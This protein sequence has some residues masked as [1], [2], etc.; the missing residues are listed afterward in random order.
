MRPASRAPAPILVAVVAVV[1]AGALV[2][3]PWAGHQL[4]RRQ[5]PAARH[6]AGASVT[7]ATTPP[8]NSAAAPALKKLPMDPH[9]ASGPGGQALARPTPGRPAVGSPA[10]ARRAPDRPAAGG[11]VAATGQPP[12]AGGMVAAI[13]PETGK[14]GLPNQEQMRRL[15][16]SEQARLSHSSIGLVEVHHPDGSVSVDVGDRFQEFETVR[17]GPDGKKTFR[18]VSDTTVISKPDKKAAPA[19]DPAR[20][21]AEGR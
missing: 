16:E 6:A 2:A 11:M 13:D 7:R 18:C 5:A 8:P 12:A 19:A 4:A 14:L 10:V 15:S 9:L 20:K 3:L 1:V 21:E 17:I